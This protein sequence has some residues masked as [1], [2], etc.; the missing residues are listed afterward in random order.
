MLYINK[1]YIHNYR[2]LVSETTV[3]ITL[4]QLTVVFLLHNYV[5]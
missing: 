2:N 1:R 3:F 4:K 5:L